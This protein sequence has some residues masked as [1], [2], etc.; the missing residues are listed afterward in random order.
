MSLAKQNRWG[1]KKDPEPGNQPP[2]PEGEAAA[3]AAAFAGNP[4]APPV[5]PPVSQPPAPKKPEKK[6]EEPV[7]PYYELKANVHRRL[8]EEID[9]NQLNN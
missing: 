1:F 6:K 4:V 8:I 2:Q 7:D 9:L 3:P 5:A